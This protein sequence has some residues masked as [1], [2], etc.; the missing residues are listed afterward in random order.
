MGRDKMILATIKDQ[1]EYM[2][3]ES[4][5]DYKEPNLLHPDVWIGEEM[6]SPQN[7]MEAKS[8]EVH[9]KFVAGLYVPSDIVMVPSSL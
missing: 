8:V 9:E 5:E 1:L 3:L 6:R 4:K 7:A 2:Q